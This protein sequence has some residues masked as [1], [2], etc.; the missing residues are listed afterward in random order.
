M[1]AGGTQIHPLLVRLLVRMAQR[2][3]MALLAGV[4]LLVRMA[5]RAGVALLAGMALLVRVVQA[6][7]ALLPDRTQRALTPRTFG[8]GFRAVRCRKCNG[9]RTTDLLLVLLLL[10]A[11]LLAL[12][13]AAWVLDTPGNGHGETR[14]PVCR[15]CSTNV[16]V[17]VAPVPVKDWE[18]HRLDTL[19]R[20]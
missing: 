19:C 13:L 17:I 8:S 14:C 3:G 12:Q 1:L 6:G 7:M 9:D 5:Q 18:P 10:L 15:H 4:A 11:L 2:A 20:P 16:L